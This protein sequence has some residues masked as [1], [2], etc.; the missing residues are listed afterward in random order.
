VIDG[1]RVKKIDNDEGKINKYRWEVSEDRKLVKKEK[2]GLVIKKDREL[3]IKK[4]RD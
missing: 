1:C 3:A 2:E 4:I